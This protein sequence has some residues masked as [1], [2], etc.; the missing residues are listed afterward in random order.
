VSIKTI[1]LAGQPH[2][3][4][5]RRRSP[6][7][8]PMLLPLISALVARPV[9]ALDFNSPDVFG[10]YEGPVT[11]AKLATA[12]GG[13]EE[14]LTAL[15]GRPQGPPSGSIS[16]N[17]Q[18]PETVGFL[19][20]PI[21][22]LSTLN[23]VSDADLGAPGLSLLLDQ[24]QLNAL[25]SFSS[26]RVITIGAGGAIIDTRGFTVSLTGN[27]TVNGALLK[28]GIG[29]L[30]LT[31]TNEWHEAPFVAN[32]ILRGNAISLATDIHAE[33]RAP[34]AIGWSRG[35]E[36]NQSD[37]GIYRHRVLGD[38]ALVKSGAGVLT[39]NA[40]NV[41]NGGTVI[42][43]GTLQLGTNAAIAARGLEIA[44]G[45]MFDFGAM[46][47]PSGEFAILD[48]GLLSGDGDVS[49]GPNTLV[50]D[51]SDDSTFAGQIAGAGSFTIRGDADSPR[52][53]ITDTQAYTGTT[54]VEGATL[55]L[56][57]GGEINRVSALSLGRTPSFGVIDVR[58]GFFDISAAGG[59]R[60]VGSLDGGGAIFF[61]ARTLT[62]GADN[63]DSFYNGALHGNGG[64]TKIGAGD[65]WLYG[66]AEDFSGVM[67]IEDG[68]L[69]VQPWALGST[70]VNN[71][72]LEFNFN[73]QDNPT[74]PISAYS[75]NITGSGK[76]SKTGDGAV[77][78]RG[79]NTYTGGTDIR[80]GALIGNTA[81]LQ[82]SLAIHDAVA[83]FY[84]VDDGTFGGNTSGNG[85]LLKYGPGRLRLS[86]A[87][88]HTGGT[89]FSGVLRIASVTALGAN[90]GSVGI[91]DGTLEIETDITSNHPFFYAGDARIDTVG[92]DLDLTGGSSGSGS[93][94]KLGL[95]QLTL[96]GD[97]THSGLTRVAAG[98]LRVLG[99]LAGS[100]A[101]EPAA[102]LNG[103]GTINGDL[104]LAAG[105]VYAVTV[106]AAGGVERLSIGGRTTLQGGTALEINAA[107][108]HY[109]PRTRYTVLSA[110]GGISGQFGAVSTDFAFLEP[111]LAYNSTS[112]ELTLARN[113]VG[114]SDLASTPEQK[115]F[116]NALDAMEIGATGD[117][118]VV[119]DAFRTLTAPEVGGALETIGGVSLTGVPRALQSQ[120]H[121]LTQQIGARLS[122]LQH[123]PSVASFADEFDRGVLLAMH[124]QDSARALPVYAAA[125]GAA[126]A[127]AASSSTATGFWLRGLGGAGNFDITS[128]AD[129]DLR[130]VG[131]L[132]GFDHQPI[133]A[134]TLG[135]LA[136]YTDSELEQDTPIS[137][138]DMAS[139]RVGGYGRWQ[140]SRVHVDALFSY[141]RDQF[142][143]ARQ[144]VIG[145]LK[146]TA[147]GDFEGETYN[148]YLEAGYTYRRL[149]DAT[150]S[151]QPYLAVQWTSLD[152]DAYTETG[153]DALNLAVSEDTTDSLRSLAGLRF[154]YS[155]STSAGAFS[156]ELRGAWAHEFAENGAFSA[157]LAG[158][159]SG[160]LFQAS[161]QDNSRDS[162]LVGAGIAMQKDRHWRVFADIDAE[163]N[164]TQETFGVGAGLR[165]SW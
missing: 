110:A 129:A 133:A 12:L 146:R 152:R 14:L 45:A 91:V 130:A 74:L 85:L 47:K 94:T 92:F 140:P 151:V 147:H 40:I 66:S 20:P 145:P 65:Q 154:N 24:S 79:T 142:D 44:A 36:F 77:W 73:K 59:D 17:I 29:M 42:R 116:G 31:G 4:R 162:A 128:T 112:I 104:A 52:Y 16:T 107:D 121:A 71:A 1:T 150:P 163:L 43:E 113:D 157:R 2:E 64:L 139:W 135:V 115:A 95:G 22:V 48:V 109:A 99:T 117:A 15:R 158:D 118:S 86:G 23:A 161:G 41:N 123:A 70:V 100:L 120:N 101:V 33:G 37:D 82:G 11:E 87:N 46:R 97:Q 98:Q 124:D 132:A 78:L 126:S 69:T 148:A 18:F 61:G 25:G 81:S 122:G 35:V 50:T 63:R 153:A 10:A 8:L 164:S 9:I 3:A 55:A 137:N 49:V 57:G 6:Q 144:L 27:L 156:A 105:S 143:T 89:A 136:S 141:G 67:R 32:G 159:P 13:F 125:L 75:G 30:E 103:S 160:T 7:S 114:Y 108:G 62:I 93:V 39:L 54:R 58:D 60:E 134:L 155:R 76:V 111:A 138:T 38:L 68:T 127:Q 19:P 149:S 90:G 72:S 51:V 21:S 165:Y 106:D 84:Q 56:V 53:T 131:A 102:H 26:S 34:G 5:R 80:N 96:D 28:Q 83:A 119:L 88:A